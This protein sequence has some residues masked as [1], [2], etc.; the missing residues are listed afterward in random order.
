MSEQL[1]RMETIPQ[2]QPE[3]VRP[4]TR[5]QLPTLQTHTS[6]PTASPRVGPPTMPPIASIPI[7]ALQI[8][9]K[10]L[11]NARFA[12]TLPHRYHLRS[13]TT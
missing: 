13:H 4:S 7:S 9:S 10:E 8:H 11:K 3:H 6:H 1:N 2:Q 5:V 12:N